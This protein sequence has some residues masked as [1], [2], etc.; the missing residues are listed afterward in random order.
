MSLSKIR[1]IFKKDARMVNIIRPFVIAN[2]G[3]FVIAAVIWLRPT[4]VSWNSARNIIARQR[5]VYAAYQAQAGQYPALQAVYPAHAVLQ[6]AYLAAAMAQ[7]Q[8]LVRYY[9]LETTLFTASEPVSHG[10][11]DG[12]SFVE[13]RVT[14][15]FTGQEEKM[16]EFTYGLAET[17]AYIRKLQIE[18]F[19]RGSVDLHVEFSLF[20]RGE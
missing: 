15:S 1:D 9:G 4:V 13:I 2:M 11:I 8:N 18:N 12:R 5:Q 17:P 19:G 16:V 6:Y 14:A 7:V 20:G 3:L 10:V